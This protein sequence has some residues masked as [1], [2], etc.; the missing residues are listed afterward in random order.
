MIISEKPAVE[1]VKNGRER[2]DD[3]QTDHETDPCQCNHCADYS[4]DSHRTHTVHV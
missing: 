3:R 2:G 4:A 1:S